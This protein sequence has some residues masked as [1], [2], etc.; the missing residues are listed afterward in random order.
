M[1]PTVEQYVA[2]FPRLKI[3][4]RVAPR[5]ES[6]F[7]KSRHELLRQAF[8]ENNW[9]HIAIKGRIKCEVC[10]PR[11]MDLFPLE[12][13]VAHG[14]FAFYWIEFWDSRSAFVCGLDCLHDLHCALLGLESAERREQWAAD[15]ARAALDSWGYCQTMGHLGDHDDFYRSGMQLLAAAMRQSQIRSPGSTFALTREQAG[16]MG[17]CASNHPFNQPFNHLNRSEFND[18]VTRVSSQP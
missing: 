3:L 4:A 15:R 13:Q 1:R 6:T 5:L 12:T 11:C 7:Y 16:H 9:E 10:H 2:R 8:L 17:L 14:Y 18:L